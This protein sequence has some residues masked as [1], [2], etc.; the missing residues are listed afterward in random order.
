MSCGLPVIPIIGLLGKLANGLGQRW[1]KL[2]IYP[3]KIINTRKAKDRSVATDGFF[4]KRA[5]R[6]SVSLEYRRLPASRDLAGWC[7]R[8]VRQYSELPPA[9]AFGLHKGMLI[10]G[11]VA[12][13]S[14][15]G[16]SDRRGPSLP[17]YGNG[18]KPTGGKAGLL[19]RARPAR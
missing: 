7:P 8:R 3:L 10:R 15:I 1:S 18:A 2:L 17:A 14:T 11:A 13:N 9:R 16:P 4:T 6:K 19:Y 12:Y 5:P